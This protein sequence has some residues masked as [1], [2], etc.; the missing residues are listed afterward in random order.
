[1]D[2]F[3]KI[4]VTVFTWCDDDI[5]IISARKA[6]QRESNQYFGDKK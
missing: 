2:A 1:M 5:R 4:I 6:T 3:G